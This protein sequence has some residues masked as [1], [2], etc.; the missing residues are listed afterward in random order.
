MGVGATGS[1]A[2]SSF[3]LSGLFLG[4]WYEIL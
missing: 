1:V 4:L 3:H 2:P